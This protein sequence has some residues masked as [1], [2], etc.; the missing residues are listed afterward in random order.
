[1]PITSWDYA[2]KWKRVAKGARVS[3]IIFEQKNTWHPKVEIQLCKGLR[4]FSLQS[5][6]RFLLKWIGSL[7]ATQLTF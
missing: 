3:E 5:W 7:F 1:M 6:C 2:V 4:L